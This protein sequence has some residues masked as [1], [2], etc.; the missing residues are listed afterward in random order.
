[1]LLHPLD[2]LKWVAVAYFMVGCAIAGFQVASAP[3]INVELFRYD[4]S[5]N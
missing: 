4:A 3:A 2:G 5:A 1:M